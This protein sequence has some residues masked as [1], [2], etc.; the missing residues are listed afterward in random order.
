MAHATIPYAGG[1]EAATRHSARAPTVVMV[2]PPLESVG[3]MAAVAGQIMRLGCGGRT[4]MEYAETTSAAA[5]AEG[6]FTKVRRHLRRLHE[7][8]AVIRRRQADIV[9]IHTCSGFS[10]FRSALDMVAAQRL[11]AKVVLHVHGAAFDE[12]Y[13]A[14]SAMSRHVIGW[15]LARADVVIALSLDWRRKLL[16]MAPRARVVVIENAVEMPERISVQTPGRTAGPCR[17]LL[18]ARMDV[19]KG[20]DDLLAACVL[21]RDQAVP[22]ELTLAGPPGTAGDERSMSMKIA[23]RHLDRHVHYTGILQGEEKCRALAS[24]N[25]YVQPSHS[26]GMPIALLEALAYGLPV[27]AT[28]VG[29]VPEVIAD[30]CEGLLVPPRSPAALAGAMRRLA[31]DPA[32]RSRMSAAARTLAEQRFTPARLATDLSALYDRLAKTPSRRRGPTTAATPG[33]A[34][35][36]VSA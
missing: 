5:G 15:T 17:F 21:L 10:F 2:G 36:P 19:W 25:A 32:L 4:R 20:I 8:R 24:C 28:R 27:I 1:F 3:G 29:A 34:T 14:S 13:A 12:F 7:L 22:F 16:T 30:G 23:A 6:A 26:E 31:C 18:L 35:Q 11:G 33:V 9:H